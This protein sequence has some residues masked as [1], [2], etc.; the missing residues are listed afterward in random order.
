MFDLSVP[1][2]LKHETM[3]SVQDGKL[4][5][6]AEK[7]PDWRSAAQGVLLVTTA[8][9]QLSPHSFAFE[10]QVRLDLRPVAPS[11]QCLQY[12][13]IFPL[14]MAMEEHCM[15]GNVRAVSFGTF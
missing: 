1:K 7:F 3:F 14:Y 10:V 13:A 9:Q 12:A 2:D 4:R 8:C 6:G 5:I 15:V 11:M